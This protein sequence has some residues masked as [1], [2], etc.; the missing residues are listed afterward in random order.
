MNDGAPK[1]RLIFNDIT[2]QIMQGELK[3]GDLVPSA[4]ELASTYNVARATV[5]KAMDELVKLDYVE[6]IQGK[7]TF[8]KKRTVTSHLAASLFEYYKEDLGVFDAWVQKRMAQGSQYVG[9]QFCSF[10]ADKFQELSRILE[11]RDKWGVTYFGYDLLRNVDK[12]TV[13]QLGEAII[14]EYTERKEQK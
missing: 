8:V 9:E 6:R 3:P 7:G 14:T 4:I 12:E 2:Q 5:V 1:Y 13:D 11:K 10:L